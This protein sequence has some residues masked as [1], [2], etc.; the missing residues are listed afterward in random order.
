MNGS[1][2]ATGDPATGAGVGDE[3]AWHPPTVDVASTGTGDMPGDKVQIEQSHIDKATMIF[4][5]LL[6]RLAGLDGGRF[7]VSVFGGSGVG[8]SEIASVLAHYCNSEG[9]NSYIMSGDNYPCR[10]PER[11]DLER[12]SVYRN[13]A[14]SVLA[15]TAG[16]SNDW[17][18][19]LLEKR[20]DMKDLT[21]DGF[22]DDEM[23]W[24]TRYV[25]AGRTALASYLGTENEIDFPMVN[26]IIESFK[27]GSD[28]L[29]L[30]R[31]GRTPDT[32]RYEAVDFTDI[33]VLFLEWTHGGNPLVAG[34]DFLVFLFSTPE[35]TL[36]HR[37]S[38]ARDK[39]TD[40][41][42]ISLVLQIEHEKLVGWAKDA[43][44]IVSKTGEI[45]SHEDFRRRLR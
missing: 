35:E 30:K 27:S 37:L 38:R 9:Y 14:L 13:G 44:L 32:I 24:A 16:F 21:P 8:K 19:A 34:I 10:I 40:S 12:L 39:N 18:E 4:P 20:P 22:D 25:D 36:A 5:R 28:T 41:P 23:T 17:M 15:R 26:S 6:P 31:M 29:V 42:L 2:E 7:V 45:L 11:N 33:Q 43:D 3:V 1:Q